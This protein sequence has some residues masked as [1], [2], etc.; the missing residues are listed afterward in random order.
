MK[1]KFDMPK[2][3]R[4]LKRFAKDFGETNAQ[5][6]VRWSV[7]ACRELAMETQ[8]WGT[9]NT[10]GIQ[11]GAIFADSLNVLLVVDSL[12]SSGRGYRATNQ[13]KVYHVSR[14][15]A[16]LS[17]EEVNDWIELNRTR[18]RGRTARLPVYERKACDKR[19]HTAAMKIRY[20]RAG[21]AKGAW[22]GAGADIAR[23][24]TGMDRM[25]IGK[26]FLSYAQ[27]HSKWGSARPSL[28]GW[29]PFA[30]I[31]NRTAHS[32]DKNVLTRGGKDRAVAWSLKKTLAW[33]KKA[34]KR[35]NQK[36]A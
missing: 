33:Y 24:Q 21:M 30:E 15:K 36:P 2:L 20:K 10:R 31:T 16:C 35:L 5:A 13:G 11:E 4:S 1:A 18:R 7:Q 34:V 28:T 25:A 14:D 29:K 32:A 22:L 23:A 27:K 19:T 3:E 8:V 26:N 17:A 9:K 6:V 12:Q